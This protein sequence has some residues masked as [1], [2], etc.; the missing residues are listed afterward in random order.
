MSKLKLKRPAP[1]TVLG[2]LALV[3]ALAGNADA[4]T[5][6]TV[7]RKGDIAKGA[8]TANALAKGAVHAKALAKGAVGAKALGKG[9]VGAAALAPDAVTASAIAPGSVYGGALGPVTIHS[10]LITDLDELLHPRTWIAS[11]SET[12]RC[13]C[14][15]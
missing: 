5:N 4:L 1:G 2:T 3:V 14:V 10:A 9:A 11:S 15:V 13:G 8:V 6:H 7:V 12:P